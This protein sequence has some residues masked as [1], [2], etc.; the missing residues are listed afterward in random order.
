MGF[1]GALHRCGS[2]RRRA[3]V[4]V[5][6]VRI[7]MTASRQHDG[8]RQAQCPSQLARGGPTLSAISHHR[9]Y[10]LKMCTLDVGVERAR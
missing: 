10:R 7:A 6:I 8:Q 5:V 1:S 2:G 9:S 3:G 4:V